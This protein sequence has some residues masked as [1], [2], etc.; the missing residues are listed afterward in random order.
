MKMAIPIT[1]STAQWE[2]ERDRDPDRVTMHYP[3]RCAVE[4]DISGTMTPEMRQ[5]AD[6]RKR[7]ELK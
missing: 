5:R 6:C 7:T 4:L 3:V 1:M 2:M